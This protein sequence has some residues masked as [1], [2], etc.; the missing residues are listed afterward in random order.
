MTLS[1]ERIETHHNDVF[2]IRFIMHVCGQEY[3]NWLKDH[4]KKNISGKQTKV[5][6]KHGAQ[7]DMFPPDCYHF[8][9]LQYH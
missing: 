9:N 6:Y 1:V 5:K 2:D 4:W 7:W 3:E 8:T